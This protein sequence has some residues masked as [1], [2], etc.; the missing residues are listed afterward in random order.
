MIRRRCLVSGLILLSGGPSLF[1]QQLPPVPRNTAPD[2][3]RG[4]RLFRI[5]TDVI[6]SYETA[7]PADPARVEP[8]FHD[9]T[10]P[11]RRYECVVISSGEHF[12]AEKAIS[13]VK[14]AVSTQRSLSVYCPMTR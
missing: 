6:R 9:H 5:T 4:V 8:I 10:E 13:T 14:L 3:I 2:D 12:E 11:N 1:A 7:I